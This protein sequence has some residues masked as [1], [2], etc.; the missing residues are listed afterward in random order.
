MKAINIHG[1]QVSIAEARQIQDDLACRVS[2]ES[3]GSLPQLVAGVDISV[4]RN[5]TAKAAVVILTYPEM[6]PIEIK[7]IDGTLNFPYVPG[8]LTF[9]EAPLVLA[10]CEK[11]SF[12]PDIILVDGQGIAHPRRFGLASHLGILFDIPT[13]GCAKS[14]LC[15]KHEIPADK[16]GCYTELLDD[17]EVIGAV[18]RTKRGI[19]PIYVSIGHKCDLGMAVRIVLECCRGYRIPQPTRLAHLAAN[20]ESVTNMTGLMKMPVRSGLEV[21]KQENGNRR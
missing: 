11:L 12:M 6:V 21:Y 15:G 17:G 5:G 10:A 7:T 20:G 16:A 9:R 19:K 4:R 13:I 1:W 14:R 2:R 18:L 3:E 8:L